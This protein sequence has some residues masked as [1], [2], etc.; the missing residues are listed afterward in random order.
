[1]HDILQ[2]LDHN[3]ILDDEIILEMKRSIRRNHPT[4]DP[5]F[6]ARLLA[7]YLN[8][9]LDAY[10]NGLS[11]TQMTE[12]RM[13]IYRLSIEQN[14][15]YVTQKDILCGIIHSNAL[16]EESGAYLSKWF[17]TY[18][19]TP[20]DEDQLLSIIKAIDP[21]AS[22]FMPANA[23]PS[24]SSSLLSVYFTNII[25]VISSLFRKIV[26]KKHHS[27]ALILLAFVIMLPVM[28]LIHSFTGSRTQLEGI[29]FVHASTILQQEVPEKKILSTIVH[30][31]YSREQ[32]GFP[33][34]LVYDSVDYLE[35]IT[36]LHSRNSAFTDDS[37]LSVID[38]VAFEYNVHPLLLLAII[39]QEQGF[40]PRDNPYALKILNN[41][42]NVYMSWTEYNTTLHDSCEV[43][44]GTIRSILETRPTG[45]NP[46]KWL[47]R[48]YAEDP[49]WWKGVQ[50]LYYTLLAHSTK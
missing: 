11:E 32:P 39:G 17:D 31:I 27:L 20:L 50:E 4:S 36:Y 3:I 40:V 48:R 16:Q 25:H 23:H 38:S 34:F 37:Y 8:D 42:F 46:F 14:A 29:S 7:Q 1:M 28:T 6:R 21:E 35:V 13:A 15:I 43:A 41:P 24:N 18:T 19:D 2:C 44:A 33:D 12:I 5:K 22:A 9:K 45:F 47:N 30:K 10:L 26:Q 49:N